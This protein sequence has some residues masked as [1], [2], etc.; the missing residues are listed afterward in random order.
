MNYL[1]ITLIL[2]VFILGCT[3]QSKQLDDKPL[4][5][6][7][8]SR[9]LAKF[10]PEDG[11]VLLFVGQE[12]E[13]IGGLE[14]YSDGYLNH[15][16]KPAG[17]TAYTGIA[18]GDSSFGYTYQGLEGIFE[19]NNWGDAN[20]N[21]SMQVESE[22]YSNMALAIG[23][24]MVNHEQEIAEGVWDENIEKLGEFLK[25]LA[26]RPVFLRTGY[27]FDGHAWNHYNKEWHIKAYK[28]VKDKLDA[29]GVDNVAYVWQSTGW[30]STPDLLEEW[31]PGD[32]Y[33]DWCA[34]SFFDRWREQ[35]MIEFARKKGK[36]VFIAEASPTVSDHMSKFTGD[37]KHTVLS[38]ADQ[39]QEAWDKWFVPFF[40]TIDENP[41]VVKA[42][43]YIN[44]YWLSHEMWKENPTFKRIDARLQT[45]ASISEKWKQRISDPK[46]IHS[47]ETLY[48]DLNQQ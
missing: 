11:K 6:V 43:S 39:A 24:W 15:F 45:S 9:P 21:M 29:M 35:Q 40:N 37:T 32:E 18:A 4:T 41:D 17:W 44:C 5:D 30:V 31:Y 3:T 46:Y 28:H 8:P 23:M 42:V 22:S 38:D 10:E 16:D 12:L 36:P 2:S 48:Q 7:K 33:V 20:S 47:S 14:E 19:T 34:F 27:E 25:S 1:N 26:P 13:A